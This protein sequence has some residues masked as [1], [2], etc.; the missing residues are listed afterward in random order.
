MTTPSTP[1][2]PRR[3]ARSLFVPIRGL[4]YHVMA[5]GDPSMVTP[6]TPSLVLVHGWMDVGASFQFVVDAL[7]AFG[8]AGGP[9]RYVIAP[10]WRGFGLSE[11]ATAGSPTDTFWFPDYLG[12]LDAL[13]RSPGL[14]LQDEPAIDLV[15][16][17]M[18]GNV[19][20]VYAGIRPERIRRLV[21]LEGFGMPQSHPAQAPRRYAQW[22]DQL[23]EPAELRD[24]D[25]LDAV[26]G[27]LRKTNPRLRP[28]FADWLAPH[29]SKRNAAGRFEILGD[30]AHKHV[31]PM[32]YRKEEVLACWAK[33]T[34][35]V[36]WVEGNE[37][38][39]TKWW[40]DR[41][42][43]ADFE[44]RLE[45]VPSLTRNL[46]SPCGHMLHH[47]QPDAVAGLLAGHLRNT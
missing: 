24:Y 7:D 14:G 21:N 5:W 19:V 20:M 27:R 29:W 47:D 3:A 18:G 36:L 41:F 39:V 45:V 32:L 13:L 6:E 38:D 12:D 16:H 23:R 46:L 15:G 33:I 40:G 42:P 10:D 1:Y 11:S 30:P 43:R 4:R 44:S 22:L 28:D 31:N 35:P 37:T 2:T 26:A 8:K 34:A 9:P 17:S 25:S